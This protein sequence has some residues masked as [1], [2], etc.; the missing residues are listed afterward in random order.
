LG[1][2]RNQYLSLISEFKTNSSK[3]FRKPNPLN[4]LPKFPVRI[5]ILEWWKVEVGFVLE[6]DIKVGFFFEINWKF[7]KKLSLSQSKSA[8]E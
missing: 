5:N 8:S 1:I 3:I 4:F 6:S 2:G 7:D